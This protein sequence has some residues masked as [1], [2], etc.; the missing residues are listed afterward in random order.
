MASDT[1]SSP[2]ITAPMPPNVSVSNRLF[3]EDVAMAAA[4]GGEPINRQ[5]V[6]YEFSNGRRFVNPDSPA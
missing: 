5:D 4:M 2:I 3:S 1:T 6:A